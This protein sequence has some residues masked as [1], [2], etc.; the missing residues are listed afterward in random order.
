MTWLITP[1][2]PFLKQK[3]SAVVAEG[4]LFNTG[5]AIAGDSFNTSRATLLQVNFVLLLFSLITYVL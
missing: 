2:I 1:F 5:S 3:E 4:G